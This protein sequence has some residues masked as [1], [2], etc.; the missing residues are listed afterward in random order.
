MHITS[1]LK[2][3]TTNTIFTLKFRDNWLTSIFMVIL[4]YKI[5]HFQATG[6]Y[7]IL[8]LVIKLSSFA[9]GFGKSNTRVQDWCCSGLAWSDSVIHTY[10]T[11][12]NF[13]KSIHILMSFISSAQK[14]PGQCS[15]FLWKCSFEKAA[16]QSLHRKAAH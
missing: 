7:G 10:F 4:K 3:L 6:W 1:F 2:A 9:H 14:R 16:V 11:T 13:F 12:L 15:K 5:S 8:E